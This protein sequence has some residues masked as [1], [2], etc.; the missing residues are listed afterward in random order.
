[1]APMEHVIG[2][3]EMRVNGLLRLGFS[4]CCSIKLTILHCSCHILLRFIFHLILLRFTF[5]V[6]RFTFHLNKSKSALKLPTWPKQEP[7][8]VGVHAVVPLEVLMELEYR[9]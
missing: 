8:V 7:E 5:Y 1:M 6:L 9:V 3:S 2:L 4:S